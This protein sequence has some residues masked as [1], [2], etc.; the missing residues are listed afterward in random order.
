MVKVEVTT[1]T[2]YIIDLPIESFDDIHI[3]KMSLEES[4]DMIREFLSDK[5]DIGVDKIIS[6]K[7]II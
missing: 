5:F 1:Q 3:D 2:T 4:D 7:E 6:V